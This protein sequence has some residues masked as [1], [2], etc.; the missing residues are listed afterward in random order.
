MEVLQEIWFLKS[1]LYVRA[2]SSCSSE[3]WIILLL[4]RTHQQ[5]F[6][7]LLTVHLSIIL[8]INQLNAQNL[9]IISLLYASTCFEHYVPIITGQN[10]ILQ[11]LV[12]SHSVGGRLVHRLREDSLNLCTRRPPTECDDTRCCIIQF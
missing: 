1:L 3:R 2:A 6:D 12:S 11:H 9:F 10:C 4:L 7:D 8:V 5:F